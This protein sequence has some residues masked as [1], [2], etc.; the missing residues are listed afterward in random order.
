M[1]T[2][3]AAAVHSLC[4]CFLHVYVLYMPPQ[5]MRD[6]KSRASTARSPEQTAIE[7]GLIDALPPRSPSPYRMFGSKN[8]NHSHLAFRSPLGAEPTDDV[9]LHAKPISPER[10]EKLAT[11]V[12]PLFSSPKRSGLLGASLGRS[13]SRSPAKS[14]EVTA[15]VAAQPEV[16]ADVAAQPASSPEPAA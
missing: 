11:P 15:D 5:A 12:R 14:P 13:P 10:V 3:E 6:F 2:T 7:L 1:H 16:T 4:A 9:S 8:D